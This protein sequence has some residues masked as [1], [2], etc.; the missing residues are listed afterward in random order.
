MNV[1][2]PIFNKCILKESLKSYLDTPIQDLH[3]VLNTC[4]LFQMSNMN[5][6]KIHEDL[7]NGWWRGPQ[8][9]M[10]NM[11]KTFPITTS[12]I[13]VKLTKSSV[14]FSCKMTGLIQ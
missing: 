6:T 4:P 9:P 10:K 1:T 3:N 13:V 12:T 14:S 11:T 2:Y 7:A 8:S 5:Y